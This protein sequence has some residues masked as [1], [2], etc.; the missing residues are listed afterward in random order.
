MNGFQRPAIASRGRAGPLALIGALGL[1]CSGG[2]TGPAVPP[3]PPV[4]PSIVAAEGETQVGSAGRPVEVPPAVRVTD[5][6]GAPLA[7]VQVTF[8]ADPGSGTVAGPAAVTDQNGIARV[9]SWTLGPDP[10]IQRLRARADGIPGVVTFIA[11]ATVPP[12]IFDIVVRFNTPGGTAAQREAFRVAESRWQAVIQGEVPDIQVT[13]GA[14]FCGSNEPID[15][16][17]DDL[18]ILVDIVPIDGPGGALGA[19]GPCLIRDPGF[20]PI[21]GRMRFDEA[22]LDAL[23]AGGTLDDVIVHEMAHVLGFGTLWELFGLL[24]DSASSDPMQASDPHFIGS[25]AQAAF[26]DIGGVAYTGDIV[27]VEDTGGPGTALSHWRESVFQNELMTGFVNQ[28]SNPLSVVTIASLED[29]GYVVDRSVAEAF[30]LQLAR[31]PS[32]LRIDLGDDL[33]RGPV[34][35][36]DARGSIRRLE[37][38]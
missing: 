25:A 8:E 33:Y 38:R 28:G 22:D 17:I 2:S 21:V 23:E 3:P 4:A 5:A 14:G 32:A 13:R 10:G 16:V 6:E 18:L 7:G 19:A 1:A 20:I 35:T 29:M 11:I 24:A 30:E 36:V 26:L 12:A 34:Y 27:P 31:A 37:I 15:E 9:G